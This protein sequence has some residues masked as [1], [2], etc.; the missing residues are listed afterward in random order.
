M[1]YSQISFF[2]QRQKML[3]YARYEKLYL[4]TKN[5]T[6]ISDIDKEIDSSINKVN[7]C[8]KICGYMNNL[9]YNLKNYISNL[10]DLFIVTNFYELESNGNFKLEPGN[11]ESKWVKSCESLMKSRLPSSFLNKH[12]FQHF[13]IYEIYKITNKKVKFLYDSLYDNLIDEVNK[14]GDTTKYLDFFFLI[15]PKE[16][17]YDK[18]KLM[19]FLFEDS[20]EEQDFILCNSFAFLDEQEIDKE[21]NLLSP[22]NKDNYMV[23]IC[24]CAYFQEIVEEIKGEDMSLCSVK[25]IIKYIKTKSENM[26]SSIIKLHLNFKNTDFYYFKVKGLVAPEYIVSYK[27]LK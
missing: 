8:L 10:N 7:S 6:N 14:F 23:V 20:Y 5:E 16:I 17:L 25:E 27:Y 21:F 13:S 22:K 26:N 18:R 15:L 2:S 24:K 4:G 19:S 1:K 3:E 9:F 12:H 11:S